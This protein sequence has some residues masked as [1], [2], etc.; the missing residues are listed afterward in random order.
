MY[1]VIYKRVSIY[2]TLRTNRVKNKV[3]LTEFNS[4]ESRFFPS[5]RLD[6]TPRVYSPVCPYYLL[7]AGSTTVAIILFSRVLSPCEKQR[8]FSRIWTWFIVSIPYDNNQY[9]TSSSIYIYIYI[10]GITG[11]HMHV[12]ARLFWIYTIKNH[13]LTLTWWYLMGKIS[14]WRKINP[15]SIPAWSISR[16]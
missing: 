6:A 10:W 14:H 2:Q 5:A 16:V 9:V 12:N 8:S 1:F 4:F 15:I 11:C 7:I 13:L 3:I